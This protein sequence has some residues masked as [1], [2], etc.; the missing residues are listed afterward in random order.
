M[1]GLNLGS[2]EHSWFAAIET[3][4]GERLTDWVNVDRYSLP[5][6]KKPPDVVANV[7]DGLPFDDDYFD[8]AYLGHLLEHL[9]YNHEI[10]VM[11]RELRRVC[12][13]GAPVR[14]VGPCVDKTVAK[15]YGQDL[16]KIMMPGTANAHM[17]GLD[18]RWV[19]TTNATLR[20]V[21]LLLDPDAYEIDIGVVCMPA[22][23]NVAPDLDWQCAIAATVP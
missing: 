13:S 5:H 15:G 4:G 12:K 7:L 22:W 1:P 18:H 16:V 23:P 11:F 8:R 14:I 3:G 20:A 19:P 17:P 6:W 9:E 2:G 21:Q 10:P